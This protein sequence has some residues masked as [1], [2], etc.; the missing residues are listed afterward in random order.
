LFSLI[1][2][3]REHCSVAVYRSGLSSCSGL[4]IARLSD[5]FVSRN[6]SG[7][8]LHRCLLCLD[9]WLPLY[10]WLLYCW[11]FIAAAMR[12]GRWMFPDDEIYF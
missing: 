5:R 7:G 2:A 10:G 11:P 12:V 8:S 1:A 3:C 6:D 9:V 4:L